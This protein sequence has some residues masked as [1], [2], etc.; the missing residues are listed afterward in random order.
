M[1]RNSFMLIAALA[2]MQA[3]GVEINSEDIPVQHELELAQKRNWGNYLGHR[4]SKYKEGNQKE[5]RKWNKFVK[6]SK[7][8]PLKFDPDAEIGSYPLQY[9]NYPEYIE[10]SAD[11]K[12]NELWAAVMA[13]TTPEPFYWVEWGDFFKMEMRHAF[14][15]RGDELPRGIKKLSHT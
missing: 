8:R 2:T 12:M 9:F 6:G 7:K 15:N 10:K 14:E 1:V 4:R 13:D 11:E 5:N 3:V